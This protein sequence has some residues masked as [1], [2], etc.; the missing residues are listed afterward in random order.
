MNDARTE[1]FLSENKSLRHWLLELLQERDSLRQE[2]SDLKDDI[3]VSLNYKSWNVSTPME[4]D[5]IRF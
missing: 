5:D 1:F 3:N 2:L 4:S